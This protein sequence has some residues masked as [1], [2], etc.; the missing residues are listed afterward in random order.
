M[1]LFEFVASI[2]KYL[3]VTIVYFFMFSIIRLMYLDITH[4]DKTTASKGTP[5]LKLVSRRDSL[6][7]K[8]KECY[9]LKDKTMFGRGKK[10]DV[11]INDP[12]FSA[13]HF[14]IIKEDGEWAIIDLKSANGT[15]VNGE[16]ISDE[17]CALKMGDLIHAGQ[18]DFIF[19]S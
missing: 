18:M 16:T 6:N 8:V 14:E 15:M 1:V 10:C 2:L 5:Y 17:P 11:R 13:K 4:D 3:F 9:F 7:F 19:V 12:Y